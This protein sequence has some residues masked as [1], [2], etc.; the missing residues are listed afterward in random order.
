M[1]FNESES[2]V[3]ALLILFENAPPKMKEDPLPKQK[4][5]YIVVN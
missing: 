3:F 1:L 4:M 5:K 2:L